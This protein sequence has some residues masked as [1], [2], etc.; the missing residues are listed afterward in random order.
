MTEWNKT[1]DERRQEIRQILI[2]FAVFENA[3]L[4]SEDRLDA[5]VDRILNNSMP[6][7]TVNVSGRSGK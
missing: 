4:P 2:T 1:Q 6:F 3:P 5:A 7:Q